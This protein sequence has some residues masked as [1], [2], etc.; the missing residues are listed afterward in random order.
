MVRREATNAFQMGAAYG[1]TV[2]DVDE[3][4]QQQQQQRAG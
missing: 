2:H 1:Q 4:H 3:Q